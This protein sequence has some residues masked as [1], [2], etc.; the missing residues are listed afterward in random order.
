MFALCVETKR[1]QVAC[2]FDS[3]SCTYKTIEPN[4]LKHLLSVPITCLSSQA[5][6]LLPLV[7]AF[8]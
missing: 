6:V 3:D 7:L 4:A 5:S 8:K 2:G 1:C